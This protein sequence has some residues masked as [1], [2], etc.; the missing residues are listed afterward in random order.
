MKLQKLRR[1]V[2]QPLPHRHH[3]FPAHVDVAS[4]AEPGIRERLLRAAQRV[5]DEPRV[6]PLSFIADA[7]SA[8]AVV[9]LVAPPRQI[10]QEILPAHQ[11]GV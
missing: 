8:A 11:Y 7:S 6:G 2:P 3:A 9:A 4:F 10:R 1:F 5:H